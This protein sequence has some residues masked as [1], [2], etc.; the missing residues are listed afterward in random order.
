MTLLFWGLG[1]ISGIIFMAASIFIIL[2]YAPNT[3]IPEVKK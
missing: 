2:L 3:D 1:F